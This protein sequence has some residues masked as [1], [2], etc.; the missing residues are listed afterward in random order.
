MWRI[1]ATTTPRNRRPQGVGGRVVLVNRMAIFQVWASVGGFLAAG[2]FWLTGWR[3]SRFGA[4]VGGFW[5]RGGLGN[6]GF[7]A[8]LS[9]W[10]AGGCSSSP[11][12]LRSAWVFVG[13]EVSRGWYRVRAGPRRTDPSAL[14]PTGQ[15][16]F[17]TI[18]GHPAER[19]AS[20]TSRGRVRADGWKKREERVG[21]PE[22]QS[23]RR[24]ERGRRP[25]T[26][27]RESA[28]PTQ[29]RTSRPWHP[30]PLTVFLA[31]VA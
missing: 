12:A 1:R 30:T 7:L 5:R 26:M 22:A 13:G 23:R 8:G 10:L 11:G 18:I 2:L 9:C 14:Y 21:W 29:G 3:F 31:G 20:G 4:S 6:G 24:V 27:T 28:T 15:R 17:E 16:G 19:M 25:D